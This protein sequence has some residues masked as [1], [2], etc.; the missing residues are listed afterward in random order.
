MC[1]LISLNANNGDVVTGRTE[2][3]SN[4]YYNEIVTLPRN[5]QYTNSMIFGGKKQY[6]SKYA[7]VGQ[8]SGSVMENVDLRELVTDGMN[9]KG[10]SLSFQ[11]YPGCS[12]YKYVKEFADDQLDYAMMAIHILGNYQTVE[13]VI[14][15]IEAGNEKEMFVMHEVLSIPE[16]F[17]VIDR[18]GRSIVCEPDE[19]GKIII[20]EGIGIMT[21]SPDYDWHLGNLRANLGISQFEQKN[22]VFKDQNQE[23]MQPFGVSGAY[24]LPGDTSPGSRFIRAAYLRDTT[25]KSTIHTADEAV[26]RLWKIF[27][28]FE[29]IPGMS[30]KT[31]PQ[32]IKLPE[33]AVE[34]DFKDTISAHNDHV[35]IKDLTNLK[36]YYRDW[37]NQSIRFVDLNDYLEDTE[38][39][40]IKITEDGSIKYQKTV[41]K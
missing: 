9:E 2:E 25:T 17:M 16:H 40:S 21:N 35:V 26:L 12:K 14:E 20:K 28:L 37:S 38:V 8:N 3:F 18:S 22:P 27:N 30:L 1:T 4:Y 41:L 33:L 15:F 31:I 23:V 13:E 19:P 11:Y 32:G 5:Y 39:K 24:G 36:F 34:T 29:I 6:Q 7:I 10:L